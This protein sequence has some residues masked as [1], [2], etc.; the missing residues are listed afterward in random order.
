MDILYIQ[1][2]EGALADSQEVTEDIRFDVDE[3]GNVLGI[4]IHHARK[5]VLEPVSSEII[6]LVE[7][8]MQSA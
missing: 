7:K 8:S 6:T 4:E 5:R 3:K 2:R 1:V